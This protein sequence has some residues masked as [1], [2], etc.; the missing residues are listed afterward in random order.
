MSESCFTDHFPILEG[1]AAC[2]AAFIAKCPDVNVDA[3]REE[4]LSRLK[5]NHDALRKTLGFSGMPFI[6]A[7]QV[8]G[9]EIA[10][11]HAT[12][13]D[14]VF[15]G[16][17]GLMTNQPNICL[18][19]YVA[20]CAAV[21]LIDKSSRAIALVHSGKKGTELGIV[22]AAIQR[23][24]A[25]YGCTPRDLIIQIA[26]CIRPPHYEIDFAA[27]IVAQAHAEGVLEVYDDEVCTA[28]NPDRYYSY[29]LEK[30]RTGRMLALLA[31]LPRVQKV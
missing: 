13:E 11:V 30:G 1:H 26:P 20:D 28:S 22:P 7:E 21:Y 16:A 9:C 12:L 4:A 14:K 6:T 3:D 24:E 27:E 2:R 23:M 29:R 5:Q 25:E 17:D 31:L 19:I 18:G 15:S 8:H 10:T